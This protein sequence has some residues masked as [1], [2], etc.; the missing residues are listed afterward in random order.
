VKLY[1]TLSHSRAPPI[2]EFFDANGEQW[3]QLSGFATE[4]H[5]REGFEATGPWQPCQQS[6]KI[7]ERRACAA[8][9]REDEEGWHAHI[10]ELSCAAADVAQKDRRLDVA[11]EWQAL[12][13]TLSH[14]CLGLAAWERPGSAPTDCEDTGQQKP[15]KLV[16]TLVDSEQ[17]LH[18]LPMPSSG[19]S[20]GVGRSSP[21]GSRGTVKCDAEQGLPCRQDPHLPVHSRV[22]VEMDCSWLSSRVPVEISR[23]DANLDREIEILKAVR[24]L[25]IET[26]LGSSFPDLAQIH[27][28]NAHSTDIGAVKPASMS[29][30]P[31]EPVR[32]SESFESPGEALGMEPGGLS[33]DEAEPHTCPRY[34]PLSRS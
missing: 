6:P 33:A 21:R 31:K 28:L 1:Q 22:S 17:D 7:M 24:H 9:G 8:S 27:C 26:E 20:C 12:G 32:P 11:A 34:S 3:S 25:P 2:D 14:D 16:P 30:P 5:W 18:Q 23:A 13:Q 15:P 19:Q 29:A 4:C 10:R